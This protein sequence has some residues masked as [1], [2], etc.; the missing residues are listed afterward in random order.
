M[1]IAYF[2]GINQEDDS[3]GNIIHDIRV[4]FKFRLSLDHIK[5]GGAAMLFE[6]F[7]LFKIGNTEVTLWL[8]GEDAMV[9]ITTDSQLTLNSILEKLVRTGRYEIISRAA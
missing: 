9:Y 4:D 2:D 6:I 3:A 7:Y 5:T 1:W 8:L